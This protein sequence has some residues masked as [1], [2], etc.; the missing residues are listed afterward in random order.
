M[1]PLR[2]ACPQCGT[3]L[4]TS[5]TIPVGKR[6]KCPTCHARFALGMD[7]LPHL[8]SA[9]TNWTALLLVL[10]GAA[11]FLGGGA[12]LIW[13]DFSGDESAEQK[14]KESKGSKD[15]V[16]RGKLVHTEKPK[17]K[18][19]ITYLSPEE[20]AQVD[21]AIDRG[22]AYLL[23]VQNPDGSWT[24]TGETLP[25]HTDGITALVGVTLLECGVK[26]DT[27]AV[28][29]AAAYLRGREKS[30]K[31]L[32]NTYEI[33]LAV[34]FFD[35]LDDPPDRDVF[36]RLAL[37]LVAGQTRTGG[38]NYECPVLSDAD[39]Q[40]LTALLEGS[41]QTITIDLTNA[42]VTPKAVD[43]T[44]LSVKGGGAAPEG[45][46]RLPVW[47]G[48]FPSPPGVDSDNSNTQFAALALWAAKTRGVPVERTL[49]RLVQRFHNTQN[50][51]GTWGY[52]ADGGRKA[53][54][55][56][57]Q[58]PTTMTCA[59]LLGLAVGQGLVSEAHTKSSPAR[60]AAHEDPA[61]KRGLDFL[62][63]QVGEAHKPWENASGVPLVNLY[64]LW[65]LERMGV[66]F[67]LDKIGGK[68]WYGWGAEILVAHQ[69]I[70]GNKGSWQIGNY[71]GQHP[72]TNTCFALLFL[73]RANLAKDLT[74]KL[75]QLMAALASPAR[76]E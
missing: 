76:K 38:W 42:R 23:S 32:A 33:S 11:I 10:L 75:E 7:Q 9:G 61:I 41:K 2:V 39:A 40:A 37:R 72:T 17:T 66:I 12:A 45:L 55:G 67:G 57:G 69:T 63:R 21:K 59:G 52:E 74:D 19:T 68:D 3:H 73:K 60:K 70:D 65:S 35:L 8:V 62:A 71:Y 20:Q 4:K 16:H 58:V 64:Y 50:P 46:T 43:P 22:I 28:Q 51:E 31:K 18:K 36:P 15:R 49:A 25:N 30:D 44:K 24:A 13:Y 34:L 48:D 14:Q 47:S 6:L 27:A 1:L 29:K 5:K 53:T 56:D 26:K 54:T